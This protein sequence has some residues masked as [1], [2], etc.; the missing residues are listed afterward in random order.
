MK[1]PE[2]KLRYRRLLAL[3]FYAGTVIIVV[4]VI[5]TW[6]SWCLGK[7]NPW[8]WVIF[9]LLEGRKK[10]SRPALLV[11]WGLLGSL[12]VAGWTRQLARSRRFRAWNSAGENL[13]VPGAGSTGSV[14]ESTSSSPGTAS[15]ELPPM[16]PTNGQPPTFPLSPT[17]STTSGVSGALG[18]TF[19]NLPNLPQLPNGATVATDLLD[20]ADKHVPT[21]RLNA[22]RKFF[23]ALTVVMFVPGVA[24]DVSKE[25]LLPLVQV[26]ILSH[27]CLFYSPLS[28]IYVSAR[29]L[30][31]LHLLNTSVTSRSIP[32][33]LL[34]ISS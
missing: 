21:L 12:S 24:F 5:G 27:T 11:Y 3:G 4:G 23:H 13:I 22:R 29:P 30:L 6:T 25:V 10:W 9:W 26:R 17:V 32:S 8:I 34:C 1:Y 31:C 33:E 7:R 2:Q 19:P 15:G 14:L 20:A 18:L 16:A 28:R